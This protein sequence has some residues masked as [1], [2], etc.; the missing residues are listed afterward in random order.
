MSV[1]GIA[2]AV[3]VLMFGLLFINVIDQLIVMQFF[4]IER[5]H[6]TVTFA[7]PRSARAVLGVA[8]L[9]G[10]LAVEPQRVVAARLRVGPRQ[11]T[12][13]LT[14]IS[15]TAR[16]KRIVEEDGRVLPPPDSGLAISRA[17]AD[18]LGVAP[19][20]PVTVEV[21][22]GARPV[23]ELTVATLVDD[24]FGVA[25]YMELN[26]L[27]RVMREG[28]VS[29][30]ALLL[31]DS[32]R[33]QSLAALLE[34]RPLVAGTSFSHDVARQFR[35]TMSKN[36]S[37]TTLINVLFAAVIAMGVVY[38]AARVSLSEHSRELASL[39]VL[40]FTRAEI[41]MVLLGELIVLTIVALPIGWVMGYLLAEV[42]VRTAESEVY[43][44]PL[45]VAPS[46]V[47]W[48]SLG[49][50]AAAV[51]SGLLVRRRLDRLDLVAVLKTQE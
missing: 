46:A 36:L 6:A 19:G 1:A 7:Q 48:A 28:D 50:V 4:S 42:M 31:I 35:D 9:P 43:R 17:L 14:G 41:S 8:R 5:Q 45:T 22:E 44:I 40:G 3:A 25:A 20:A 37:V 29:T 33:Q 32:A 30:G 2:I 10:V 26:A 13:A 27:H 23:R 12:V 51:G 39:R 24:V 34:A 47:A 16:L 38:N 15:R 18:A 11:R 21:L 49:V